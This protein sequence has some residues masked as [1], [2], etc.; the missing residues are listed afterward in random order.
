M[1]DV[2]AILDAVA[3]AR[4]LVGLPILYLAIVGAEIPLPKGAV[5]DAF[6]HN[7]D[8]MTDACACIDVLI[9]DRDSR[10]TL[11]RTLVKSM[12]VSAPERKLHVF[13]SAAELATQWRRNYQV[14][15]LAVLDQFRVFEQ[16]KVA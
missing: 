10:A 6:N 13:G 3:A 1:G 2:A 4:R 12:A 15:A 9:A 11:H 8:A 16:T 14:D 7:F 5:R